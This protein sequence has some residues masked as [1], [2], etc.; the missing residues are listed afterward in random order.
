MVL[1]YFFLGY[2]ANDDNKPQGIECSKHGRDT[3]GPRLIAPYYI[4]LCTVTQLPAFRTTL[5]LHRRHSTSCAVQSA[6]LDS[7]PT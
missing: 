4:P 5:H 7:A 1:S 2:T 6:K 3:N